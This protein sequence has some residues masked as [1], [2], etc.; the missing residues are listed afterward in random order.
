MHKEEDIFLGNN[1]NLLYEENMDDV[2]VYTM[3]E[4]W[5]YGNGEDDTPLL[6]SIFGRIYDVSEGEKFYG[7]DGSY[8]LFAGR[9][10]TYALS[11]GCKT[12]VEES[13]ENLDE[14]QLMEG[15]R[16]LSF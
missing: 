8:P 7:P 13:A 4:L 9:D 10:V 5:E 3:E 11:T 12:C 1:E 16:W 2:P 6:I 14:K 15:K